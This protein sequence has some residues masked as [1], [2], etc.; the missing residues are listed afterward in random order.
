[1]KYPEKPELPDDPRDDPPSPRRACP[2][3]GLDT[4]PVEMKSEREV[5][6]GSKKGELFRLD[7][8]CPACEEYVGTRIDFAWRTRNK[9]GFDW[10]K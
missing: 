3:C 8:W 10:N 2:S 4:D 1:M 5:I 6:E 9:K 7:Y